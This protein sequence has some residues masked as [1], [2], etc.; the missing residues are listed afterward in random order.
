ML[1]PDLYRYVDTD[2]PKTKI[3][4]VCVYYR[5]KSLSVLIVIKLKVFKDK[6]LLIEVLTGA[7]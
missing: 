5:V 1:S 6:L 7:F 3:T 2:R 4:I